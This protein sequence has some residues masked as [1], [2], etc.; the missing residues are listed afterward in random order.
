[1]FSA[2]EYSFFLSTIFAN[3]VVKEQ[4]R[5]LLLDNKFTRAT[6]FLY[7][8]LPSLRADNDMEVPFCG[9]RKHNAEIF[10]FFSW[11]SIQTLDELNEMEEA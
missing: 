1:M 5:P 6:R 3:L 9:G 7:I 10:F 11:T 2:R 4:Q 8:S